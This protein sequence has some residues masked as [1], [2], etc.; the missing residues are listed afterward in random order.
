MH[1]LAMTAN[2]L[3]HVECRITLHDDG[4]VSVQHFDIGR[5]PMRR[6]LPDIDALPEPIRRRLVTLRILPDPPSEG[7]PDVGMRVSEDVFYIDC[8]YGEAVWP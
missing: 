3:R 8:P 1:R 7:I 5:G 6:T 4:G 2:N